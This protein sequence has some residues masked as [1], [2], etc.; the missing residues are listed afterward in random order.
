MRTTLSVLPT[1][2]ALPSP[3]LD[4]IAGDDPRQRAAAEIVWQQV[5]GLFG[6]VKGPTLYRYGT[7]TESTARLATKAAEAEAAGF[8]HGV[9]TRD[10]TTAT[11]VSS[12]LRSDVEQHFTVT[13]TGA[14]PHHYTVE[15]P[16]PVTDAVAELFNRIFGRR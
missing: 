9:S 11:D 4:F 5:A 13:K 3:V 14:D 6:G 16:K 8:P 2:P 10:A 12:A 7:A 1:P 15:L